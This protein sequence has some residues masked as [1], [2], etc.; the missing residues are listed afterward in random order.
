MCSVFTR[1]GVDGLCV[2][3]ESVSRSGSHGG[4]G[5]DLDAD[6]CVF[7]QRPAERQAEAVLLGSP[8]KVSLAR[9]PG[10]GRLTIEHVQV[11][12]GEDGERY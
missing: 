8:W 11:Q 7:A 3:A 10:S 1:G 4:P 9:P 6:W 2:L 5:G 12:Q